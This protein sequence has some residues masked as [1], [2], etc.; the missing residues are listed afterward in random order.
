VVNSLQPLTATILDVKKETDDVNTYKLRLR[1]NKFSFKP[2]QFNV[3]GLPGWG[4]AAFSFSSLPSPE[5]H[6]LHT[7]RAVGNISMHLTRLG[8]GATV[9]IRGPFGNGWPMDKAK[10]RDVLVVAGGIGMAPLR[11]LILAIL[12]K[13]EEFGK[14]A[15]LYGARTSGGLLY[16]GEM[17]KW[18]KRKGVQVL[19]SV[20]EVSKGEKWE[21]KRGVVTTLFNEV[22]IDYEKSLTF[23]CGP[24]IMMR[25]VARGLRMRGLGSSD[26]YVSLERRMKCGVAQCGHCQI[27][28]KYVCKDGPVFSYRDIIRVSLVLC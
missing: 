8:K 10:G 11:P 3:L 7:I 27:G 13:R 17:K 21:G 14:L 23:I 1:K 24:E 15:I 6:F 9:Q 16:L 20:D 25:F 18:S 5:G 28:A 2:G 22:D 19:L 26:I 4:E 12:K